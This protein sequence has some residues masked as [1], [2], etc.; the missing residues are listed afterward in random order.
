MDDPTS[1][2]IGIGQNQCEHLIPGSE[3]LPILLDR[4]ERGPFGASGSRLHVLV[5]ADQQIIW[6][7]PGLENPSPDVAI[8]QGVRNTGDRP[9]WLGAK[10]SGGA[11]RNRLDGRGAVAERGVAGLGRRRAPGTKQSGAHRWRGA[12]HSTCD[13]LPGPD[14]SPPRSLRTSP[15]ASPS[16]QPPRRLLASQDAS[17]TPHHAPGRLSCSYH[18]SSRKGGGN[19]ERRSRAPCGLSRSGAQGDPSVEGP[20]LFPRS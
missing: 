12:D 13:R 7:I 14:D 16:S 19:R 2:R 10:R 17:I 20:A 8:V 6:S 1:E 15:L 4:Q 11:Y 5:C 9:S 18:A 3:A